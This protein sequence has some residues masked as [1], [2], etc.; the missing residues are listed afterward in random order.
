MWHCSDMNNNISTAGCEQVSNQAYAMFSR[1][2]YNSLLLKIKVTL[3]LGQIRKRT[4][5]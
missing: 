1:I 2:G 5:G 3:L 4:K